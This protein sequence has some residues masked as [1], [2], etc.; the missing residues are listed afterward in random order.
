MNNWK[1]HQK[2]SEEPRSNYSAS[3]HDTWIGYWHLALAD[4]EFD[5]HK[6]TD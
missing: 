4:T 3:T 5:A 1:K 6:T 2:N